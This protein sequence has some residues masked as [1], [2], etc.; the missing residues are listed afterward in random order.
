M[1]ASKAAE[2]ILACGGKSL[3]MGGNKLL[4]DCGGIPLIKRTC[5]SFRGIEE[6]KR[7]IIAV[8]EGDIPFY[9]E[10]MSD[11]GI[12][13]LL[14]AGGKT[15]QESIH[16]AVLMAK[17]DIIIIHD[18]ARPFLS[19]EL[20]LRSLEDAYRCGSSVACV[21]AKDT[22]RYCDSESSYCPKRENLYTVQ[23][24]QSFSRRLYL[25]AAGMAE[26]SFTDDAQ[27]LD[28]IGIKPH[29][30]KGEYS[31][32]KITTPEDLVYLKNYSR[33]ELRVGHGYDVHR[34]VKGRELILGGVKIPYEKGLLGHSDADVLL[35][36]LMDALLGAA[37]LGDIGKHFPDSD[38]S[39][40][41]ISSM[42]LLEKVYDLLALAGYKPSNA[43]ITVIAQEPKLAGYI[44]KMRDNIS[45]A[46]GLDRDRI[47]VKATTEE[48]LGFTGNKEGI[49]A[50]AVVTI[51]G[52]AKRG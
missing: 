47:S 42:T 18:G 4:I 19:R 38:P 27:L 39:Y 23:T 36:A 44:Q 1:A 10:L 22:I 35:H 9:D 34:L 6:I 13:Y 5:L 24:P 26:E 29:L 12:S 28:S 50:H 40:S 25:Y 3:R 48:G 30:T 21:P 45:L 31:N 37:A 17:E 2:V 8:P 11:I 15:R 52:V 32:I 46:L 16:N 41:G 43:D 14:V 7:L 20:I 49:A 51:K 33:E